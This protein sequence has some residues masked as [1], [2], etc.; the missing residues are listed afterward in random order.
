LCFGE[1]AGENVH[2][3]LLC[4]KRQS[5]RIGEIRIRIITQELIA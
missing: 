5:M 1:L 3:D 4:G 2:F